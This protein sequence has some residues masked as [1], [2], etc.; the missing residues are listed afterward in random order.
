MGGSSKSTLPSQRAVQVEGLDLEMLQLASVGRHECRTL[1]DS[2]ALRMVV[3]VQPLVE[4]VSHRIPGGICLRTICLTTPYIPRGG[5]PLLALVDP[6]T[7]DDLITAA[8]TLIR[9]GV[10]ATHVT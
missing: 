8:R 3:L 1:T 9:T 5:A 10:Q 4:F 6:L 2:P 7:I